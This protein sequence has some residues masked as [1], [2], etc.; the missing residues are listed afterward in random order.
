MYVCMY[1]CTHK[2]QKSLNQAKK[3]AAGLRRNDGGVDG[4]KQQ[5]PNPKLWHDHKRVPSI[6][7]SLHRQTHLAA[8]VALLYR[9]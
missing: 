8:V 7:I 5:D 2:E 1:V 6:Y 3:Q 9:R 4:Q